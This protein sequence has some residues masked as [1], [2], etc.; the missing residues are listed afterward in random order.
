MVVVVDHNCNDILS[1]ALLDFVCHFAL[2]SAGSF[3]VDEILPS[4]DN[5]TY[6]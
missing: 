2:S 1:F 6:P 3:L 4:N 5:N